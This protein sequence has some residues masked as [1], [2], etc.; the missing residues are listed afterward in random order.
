[1]AEICRRHATLPINACVTLYSLHP[2][3]TDVSVKRLRVIFA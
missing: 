3:N 2:A 1:M